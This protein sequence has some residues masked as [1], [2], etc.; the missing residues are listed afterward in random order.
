MTFG[1]VVRVQL[2]MRFHA[3]SHDSRLAREKGNKNP[4]R[5]PEQELNVYAQTGMC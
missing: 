4:A 2:L 5:W 1:G 3:H